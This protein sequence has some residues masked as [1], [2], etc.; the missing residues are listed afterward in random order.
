LL[1]NDHIG[2]QINSTVSSYLQNLRIIQEHRAG[3]TGADQLW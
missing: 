2:P 1:K 3:M